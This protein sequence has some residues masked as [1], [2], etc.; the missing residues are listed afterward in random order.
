ME[1]NQAVSVLNFNCIGRWRIIGASHQRE[2]ADLSANQKAAVISADDGFSDRMGNP[3]CADGNQFGNHLCQKRTKP[4]QSAV[5]TAH[6]RL[7]A[8]CELL[9]EPD[10]F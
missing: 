9:L 5:R 8:D 6:L 1:K 4:P 2:Y 7:A 10:L 3:F